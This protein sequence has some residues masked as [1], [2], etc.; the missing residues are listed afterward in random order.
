MG[1]YGEGHTNTAV[2]LCRD[3]E[4]ISVRCATLHG[5]RLGC[6]VV[7]HRFVASEVNDNPPSDSVKGT[8][9]APASRHMQRVFCHEA[10]GSQDTGFA[11]RRD[12]RERGL[13]VVVGPFCIRASKV[14]VWD[15]ECCGWWEACGECVKVDVGRHFEDDLDEGSSEESSAGLGSSLSF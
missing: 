11:S 5:H 3:G 12:H 10:N 4:D 1:G 9:P 6:F 2:V 8:V 14:V 13:Q 7:R 15:S